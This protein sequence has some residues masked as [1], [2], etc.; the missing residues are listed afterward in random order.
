LGL[1]PLG[2]KQGGELADGPW[3]RRKGEG[4]EWELGQLWGI[5]LRRGGGLLELERD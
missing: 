1:W 3:P 5:G 2:P 4:G